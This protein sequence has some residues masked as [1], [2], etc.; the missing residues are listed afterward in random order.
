[1]S[2]SKTKGDSMIP[3]CEPTIT[4][5]DEN[6]VLQAIREGQI[7]GTAKY[8]SLFEQGFSKWLGVGYGIAV[9]SGGSAL[10]LALKALGI[11]KGDEVIV[12]DF[13]MAAVVNAVIQAGAKPV[14]VDCERETGNMDTD[15]IEQ[16]ITGNT[17]AI[18]AVHIY[19]QPCD[20]DAIQ[21]IAEQYNLFVVEDAA[22]A[23]GA[24]YKGKKVGSLS[25]IACFSFYANKIITTGEGGMIVTNNKEWA[26]KCRSLR[27][28]CFGGK[29][30]KFLHTDLGWSMCMSSLEAALGIA[31]LEQI[32]KLVQGRIDNALH[33]RQELMDCQDVI[34]LEEKPYAKCV[35]WMFAILARQ[36]KALRD[37]LFKNGVETR[38]FFQPMHIQSHVAEY[39]PEGK[40]FPNSQYLADNG[41]YLPSSSHLT[42]DN[43]EIVLKFIKE[44]YSKI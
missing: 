31:Q 26:E 29:E 20:M 36:K 8:V 43:R 11:K 39:V 40:S 33:Y 6:L 32:N 30:N 10:F 16:A 3:V 1:M 18:I 38:D 24:L 14:L 9:N 23:H 44:F 5:R 13:T 27:D 7:S 41:L 15:L 4:E 42:K 19:G 35:Y 37:F 28:Y 25:D 22:E 21:K 17:K 2:I 12:P 34:L